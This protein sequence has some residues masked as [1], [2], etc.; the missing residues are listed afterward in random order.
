M[1]KI[2]VGLH[3]SG[4]APSGLWCKPTQGLHTGPSLRSWVH[5]LKLHCHLLHCIV[6]HC[7]CIAW[8]FTVVVQCNLLYCILLYW[9]M[10]HWIVLF[11]KEHH[12]NAQD[13][14]NPAFIIEIGKDSCEPAHFRESCLPACGARPARAC[15]QDHPCRRGFTPS[16]Y[17]VMYGTVLYCIVFVLHC[18]VL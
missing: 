6:L 12:G 13:P 11:C 16:N 2:A 9:I 7:I 8:Y 5:S 1:A 18:I 4:V 3:T 17:I 14:L 10:L 15:T